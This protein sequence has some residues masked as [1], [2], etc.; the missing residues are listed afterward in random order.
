MEVDWQG[1]IEVRENWLKSNGVCP[2]LLQNHMR[3]WYLSIM[4]YKRSLSEDMK[5]LKRMEFSTD[6]SVPTSHSR[7]SAL[8]EVQRAALFQQ[9]DDSEEKHWVRRTGCKLNDALLSYLITA[10]PSAPQPKRATAT[11]KE[12]PEIF[13]L[14]VASWLFFMTLK[15]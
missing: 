14:S 11:K 5:G 9:K 1:D 10:C 13:L 12:R 3:V 6:P 4:Y 15:G 8:A 2:N 7:P